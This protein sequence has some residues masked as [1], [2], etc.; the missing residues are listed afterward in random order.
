MAT[1]D[2]CAYDKENDMD[3]DLVCAQFGFLCNMIRKMITIVFNI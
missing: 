1:V 2:L 3:S